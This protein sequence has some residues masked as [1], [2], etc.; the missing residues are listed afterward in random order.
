MGYLRSLA[1]LPDPL[2]DRL[3]AVGLLEVGSAFDEA[4]KAKIELSGTAGL[5]FDGYF[6]RIFFGASVG[7]HGTTRVFF[8]FGRLI[9]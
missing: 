5:A 9:R 3:F 6:G 8:T 1:K 2:G 4:T 7:S